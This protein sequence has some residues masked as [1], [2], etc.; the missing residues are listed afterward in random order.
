M[1]RA[2]RVGGAGHVRV[3]PVRAGM[4]AVPGG[5]VRVAA[6]STH[7]VS[8]HR[9]REGRR[10]AQDPG[11]TSHDRED[12]AHRDAGPPPF[13]HPARGLDCPS[14]AFDR[15]VV[16]QSGHRRCRRMIASATC[17]PARGTASRPTA[18]APVAAHGAPRPVDQP[19]A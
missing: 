18:W 17:R 15:W 3:S 9:P 11:R 16:G 8:G 6:A 1:G 10:G 12:L 14:L 19:I 7:R 4:I 13:A 2:E 5:R